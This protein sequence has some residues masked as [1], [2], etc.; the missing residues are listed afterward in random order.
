MGL[1]LTL[2]PVMHQTMLQAAEESQT[3]QEITFLEIQ[4][5][6]LPS[7]LLCFIGDSNHKGELLVQSLSTQWG[8][9]DG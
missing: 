2:K 5:T 4:K 1:F 7:Q 6:Q 8:P 9:A 3:Q